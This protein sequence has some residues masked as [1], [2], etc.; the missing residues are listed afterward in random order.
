MT[1]AGIWGVILKRFM[2][3]R[4]VGLFALF[5]V[6]SAAAQSP[7]PMFRNMFNRMQQLQTNQGMPLP[8]T[9]HVGN[10]AKITT[11]EPSIDCSKIRTPLG[12]ILC[13]DE[14]AAKADWDVNAAAWAFAASLD[15]EA[16]K[17]STTA[18]VL[19]NLANSHVKLGVLRKTGE[20]QG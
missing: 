19:M 10:P 6:S 12:H 15:D 4:L 16:R 7:E 5:M 1:R 20:F 9:P 14:R 2:F 11:S 13:S 18:A 3:A 8:T 17:A